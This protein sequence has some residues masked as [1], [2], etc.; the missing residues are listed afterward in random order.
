MSGKIGFCLVLTFGLALLLSM[1]LLAPSY[2][3]IEPPGER[4]TTHLEDSFI[5][6]ADSGVLVQL[7][8]YVVVSLPSATIPDRGGEIESLLASFRV[9]TQLTT[10]SD[11]LSDPEVIES[12]QVVVLDA[13]LGSEDGSSVPAEFV[14]L[15]LRYDRPVVLVG[16]AAWLLHRLR[17]LGSPSQTASINTLLQTSEGHEGVVFLS[18]PESLILGASLTSETGVSLPINRVQTERS[19]LEDL[20]DRGVS[21]Q[22]APLRHDAWPLDTFLFGPEDPSLLTNDGRG[23]LLNTIAYATAIGESSTSQMLINSQTPDGE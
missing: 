6:S 4:T 5:Q 21:G 18:L 19:R 17:G 12:A 1:P 22:L 10:V 3:S 9:H 11:T 16:R 14:T 2:S 23:L 15:L 13:S 7:G 20:T 8:S